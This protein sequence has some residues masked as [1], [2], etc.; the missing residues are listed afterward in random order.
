MNEAIDKVKKV[1]Q[2]HGI[3]DM[4]NVTFDNSH[5]PYYIL[6]IRCHDTHDRVYGYFADKV[7]INNLVKNQMQPMGMNPYH[8]VHLLDVENNVEIFPII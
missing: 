2:L 8:Y 6:A 3:S 5:F 1:L 7:T 4:D